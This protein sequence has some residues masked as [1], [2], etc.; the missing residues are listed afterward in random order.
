MSHRQIPEDYQRIIAS[1]WEPEPETEK[2]EPLTG[3]FWIQTQP[4]SPMQGREVFDDAFEVVICT[5][6]PGFPEKW[7]KPFLSHMLEETYQK[8]L[9]LGK[10]IASRGLK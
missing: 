3:N 7:I 4:D 2:W 1:F 8:G 9:D 5:V 10:E 6:P